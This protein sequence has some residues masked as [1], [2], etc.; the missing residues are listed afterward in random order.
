[1]KWLLTRDLEG[2]FFN[3]VC[4]VIVSKRIKNVINFDNRKL[5]IF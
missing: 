5:I 4:V 1:M 2:N 3:I